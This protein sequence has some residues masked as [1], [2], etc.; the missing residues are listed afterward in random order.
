MRKITLSVMTLKKPSEDAQA[1]QIRYADQL[2][3]ILSVPKDHRQMLPLE[4]RKVDKIIT[5]I[6]K[7]DGYVL[8]EDADY[9][10]LLERVQNFPW[11]RHDKG[12][13]RFVDDIENSPVWDVSLV[14]AK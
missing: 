3:E 4:M 8:L 10:E 9:E 1:P 2:V 11:G 13:L 7:S 6:E 12:I 5:L 14:D